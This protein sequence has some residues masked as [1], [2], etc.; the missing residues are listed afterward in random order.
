MQGHSSSSRMRAWSNHRACEMVFIVVLLCLGA[1]WLQSLYSALPRLPA[2]L[3]DDRSSPLVPHES[4]VGKRARARAGGEGSVNS[5]AGV[6]AGVA[7]FH[8]P[9]AFSTGDE[10][11][12]WQSQVGDVIE[13]VVS[14]GG[15]F[16]LIA[17]GNT[18][19]K[20]GGTSA[21]DVDP[22]NEEE[23]LVLQ[24]RRSLLRNT[25]EIDLIVRMP[26]SIIP[27]FALVCSSVCSKEC[28]EKSLPPIEFLRS[29][30]TCS[31]SDAFAML[32]NISLTQLGSSSWRDVKDISY[33]KR[34]R[35][36]ALCTTM[37]N[38]ELLGK[39][40]HE[41]C[42][43]QAKKAVEAYTLSPSAADVMGGLERIGG[44]RLKDYFDYVGSTIYGENTIETLEMILDVA[45]ADYPIARDG[46]DR[47]VGPVDQLAWR[48]QLP[49]GEF[50]D[51]GAGRG[52][53]VR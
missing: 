6:L 48:K 4:D 11:G 29:P 22:L 32:H 26:E 13:D 15:S 43:Q 44:A 42:A 50:V 30:I 45:M 33:I 28:Q 53:M 49:L 34:Q 9:R 3:L 12:K 21:G 19:S 16:G 2:D 47:G 38:C 14:D 51:L 27:T 10:E 5:R 36:N 20:P 8:D 40:G 35:T 1:L 7:G 24:Q 46:R 25:E 17:F 31:C 23:L 39:R 37:R 41:R 52:K 18:S